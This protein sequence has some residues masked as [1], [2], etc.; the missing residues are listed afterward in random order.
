[1]PWVVPRTQNNACSEYEKHEECRAKIEPLGR[2]EYLE[3]IVR[4]NEP[5]YRQC[6]NNNW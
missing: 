4:K 1:M 6:R 2:I 5:R 3:S